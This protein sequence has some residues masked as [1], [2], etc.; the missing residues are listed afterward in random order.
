[1][2]VSKEHPQA[3]Q[4]VKSW[5]GEPESRFWWRFGLS[6]PL[7][8]GLIALLFSAHEQLISFAY[9]TEPWSREGSGLPIFLM[10]CLG[11]SLLIGAIALGLRTWRKIRLRHH[12]LAGLC[13]GAVPVVMTLFTFISI[14]TDPTEGDVIIQ[15]PY[16]CVELVRHETL[17]LPGGVF[18][19][20]S[21]SL[22]LVMFKWLVYGFTREATTLAWKLA[23]A[24]YA[25][26]WILFL[27][28][29]F[30]YVNRK[31]PSWTN[32]VSENCARIFN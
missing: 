16:P 6:M 28:E 20:L 26:A 15:V 19:M 24:M 7:P 23:G 25:L 27:I 32:L 12:L 4:R 2:G 18:W 3:V 10:W 22:A 21:L 1:M 8:A 11:G 17:D 29:P 31:I 14:L 13:L 9:G 30:H 5:A